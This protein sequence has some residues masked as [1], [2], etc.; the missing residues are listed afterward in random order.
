MWKNIFN[1]KDVS[2]KKEYWLGLVAN[3]I[4]MYICVIPIAL[5]SV[6]FSANPIIFSAVYM[7]VCNL[8]AVSLFVRRA[9][10]LNMKIADT[11]LVAIMTP[12]ISAII[13]GLIPSQTKTKKKFSFPWTWRFFILGIG[14]FFTSGIISQI[15][16][17]V[18]DAFS[19]I[20]ISGLILSTVSM[21]VGYI[22]AAKRK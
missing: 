6:L 4:T 16:F 5:L 13:I 20:T 7:I 10:D 17:G 2:D 3:L 22:G 1:Y 12:G 18:P 11:L 9:N 21:I 19:M 15:C 8:P 14:I